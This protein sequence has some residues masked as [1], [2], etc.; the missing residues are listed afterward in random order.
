MERDAMGKRPLLMICSALLLSCGGTDACRDLGEH[1]ADPPDT[2][3]VEYGD[4]KD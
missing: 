1:S 2:I 4:E 3:G